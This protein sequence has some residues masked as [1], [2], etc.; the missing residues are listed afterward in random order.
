V[1][2]LKGRDN[3]PDVLSVKNRIDVEGPEHFRSVY[4]QLRAPN[5]SLF[6]RAKCG[7]N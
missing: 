7:L 5:E 3:L 6:G 1:E 2:E 4:H